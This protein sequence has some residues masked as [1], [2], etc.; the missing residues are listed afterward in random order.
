[1]RSSPAKT[2]LD[3]CRSVACNEDDVALARFA[4]TVDILYAPDLFFEVRR[5]LQRDY[6]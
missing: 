5:G 4:R 2:D 1:M 3:Y 6:A